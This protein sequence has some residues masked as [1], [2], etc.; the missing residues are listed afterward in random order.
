MDSPL[1]PVITGIFMID[2]EIKVGPKFSRHMTKWK[3]YTV[4]TIA[5]INPKSV[6]CVLIE[7]YQHK[8]LIY[9]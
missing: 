3:K 6:N 5:Y 1:G 2:L 8:Y 7:K 4:D 9:F